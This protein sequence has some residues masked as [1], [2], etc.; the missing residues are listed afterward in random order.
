MDEKLELSPEIKLAIEQAVAN[1]VC[2]TAHAI[3]QVVTTAAMRA[4]RENGQ[5]V[6]T[7]PVE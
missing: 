2:L 5:P 7:E 3:E 6:P 4:V 1:A